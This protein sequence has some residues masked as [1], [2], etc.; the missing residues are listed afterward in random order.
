MFDVL[1]G[2]TQFCGAYKIYYGYSETT[3]NCNGLFQVPTANYQP[4][5]TPQIKNNNQNHNSIN[6]D[7][8]HNDHNYHIA[9]L[10]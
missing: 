3:V 5:L 8:S 4:T 9:N 1:W 2:N 10:T 6:Y 7:Y